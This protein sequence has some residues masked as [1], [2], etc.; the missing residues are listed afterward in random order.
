MSIYTYCEGDSCVLKE[1]CTRYLE[2]LR[3]PDGNG[4]WWMKSCE[5]ER[6]G[7]INAD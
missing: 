7:Y 4:W 1:H 3:L 2:G 5:D 6:D